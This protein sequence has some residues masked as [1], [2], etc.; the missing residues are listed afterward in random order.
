M[1]F[2][3]TS[4]VLLGAVAT[5]GLLTLMRSVIADPL[6]AE[7]S[8][9]KGEVLEFV[10]LEKEHVIIV[11]PPRPKRPPPPDEPPPPLP[12]IVIDPGGTIGWEGEP[13][14]PIPETEGDLLNRYLDDGE[15]L[16]IVR[17]SPI[18]PRRALSRGIE[19]YVLVEFVVAETGAV[20]DPVVLFADP[21]G[22]F[23]RAAVTA[24]LKFKYKPKVF[25]GKPVAV[26]GVRSRIVFEMED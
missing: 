10:R 16:P 3:Y 4:A 15:Y 26:P 25:G 20:R 13:L 8:G 21:P 2:R 5:F 7:D 19:G 6:P 11:D 23:E 9:I 24:V 17:V 14:K 1:L 18:Y 12:P 22:F